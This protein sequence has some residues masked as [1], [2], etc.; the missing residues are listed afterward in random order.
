MAA[1]YAVNV[2]AELDDPT[3]PSSTCTGSCSPCARAASA[4][5]IGTVPARDTTRSCF[6]YT[7][8]APGERLIV[9]LNFTDKIQVIDSGQMGAAEAGI[10]HASDRTGTVNPE[11]LG[12]RPREGVVLVDHAAAV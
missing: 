1:N 10:F 2:A 12:L 9:A 6:V 3:H 4:L 5:Q 8:Q 7:R 11:R